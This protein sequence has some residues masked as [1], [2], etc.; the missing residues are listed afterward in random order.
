MRAT[1]P[2]RLTLKYCL[3]AAALA[4]CA[5]A[6][7]GVLSV[8]G[9]AAPA[10]WFAGLAAEGHEKRLIP[11]KM[12]SHGHA[13]IKRRKARQSSGVEAVQPQHRPNVTLRAALAAG[14]AQVT[15]GLSWRV[16]AMGEGDTAARRLMWS[17]GGAEP[18]I[19]LEPGKYRVEA[20]Y[21]LVHKVRDIE[22]RGNKPLEAVLVL[23]AGTIRVHGAAVPGGAVLGDM[24]FTLRKNGAADGTGDLGRS[25]LTEAVFHVP[26]GAYQLHAQHGFAS[27]GKA[28]TVEA[29]RETAV[30]MVMNTGML[31]LSAR[32]IHDGPPLSGVAFTIFEDG[33]GGGG[34]EFARSV[35]DEPRFDLPAGRYRVAAA[36]GLARDERK[37]EV[38]AGKDTAETFV[39]DAGGVRMFSKLTGNRQPLDR[40]LLYKVYSLTHGSGNPGQ[41]L[42][43]TTAAAPTLFLRRG[44][45]RIECQYGWHNARQVREVDVTAGET[46]DAGFEHQA[47]SVTLKLVPKPGSAPL[48]QVKWTLKYSAGGTVLISQDA[49]PQLILQAGSYQAVAHRDNKT[50]SRTFDAAAN[51]EQTIEIIAE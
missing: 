22:V 11:A 51:S 48:T 7:A 18:K 10:L 35:R 16:F 26:A 34:R 21:G 32:A 2:M 33:E 43:T 25:A 38:I 44:R 24:F 39:L 17:G 29:G 20:E 4:C 37:L 46:A 14:T 36:L 9:T 45:Y 5:V 40:H 41:A 15:E 6:A 3:L 31:T 42:A 30:E 47:A 13:V 28:V 8:R 23:D 1:G 50:Y 49:S 27:A 12:V 19:H